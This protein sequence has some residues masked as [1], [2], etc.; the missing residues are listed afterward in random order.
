MPI[1][2]HEVSLPHPSQPH[3]HTLHASHRSAH[4]KT[5]QCQEHQSQCCLDDS[6]PLLVFWPHVNMSGTCLIFLLLAV[7]VQTVGKRVQSVQFAPELNPKGSKPPSIGPNCV[8][9]GTAIHTA[10]FKVSEKGPNHLLLTGIG[11]QGA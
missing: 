3:F 7:G 8:M 11:P 1:A 2:H 6:T 4:W 9:H 5:L 10:E